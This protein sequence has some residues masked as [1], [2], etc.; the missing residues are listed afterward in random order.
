M[1]PEDDVML[2]VLDLFRTLVCELVKVI[3]LNAQNGSLVL[4][5]CQSDGGHDQPQV[6]G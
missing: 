3:L 1:N 6:R 2:R 5:S 4:G